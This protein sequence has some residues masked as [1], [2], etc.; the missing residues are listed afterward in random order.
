[1]NQWSTVFHS[2]LTMFAKVF[3]NINNIQQY[4]T[5]FDNIRQC[6]EI[7]FI[8]RNIW[9]FHVP[10]QNR[11]KPCTIRQGQFQMILDNICQYCLILGNA[12]QYL[13][14][15]DNICQYWSIFKSVDYLFSNFIKIF[16]FETSSSINQSHIIRKERKGW[17]FASICFWGLISLILN[18]SLKFFLHMRINWS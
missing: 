7:S 13:I 18:Q 14:R 4:Q 11:T 17:S 8:F 15:L 10:P 1:M 2:P 16:Y 3:I 6:S 12:E 9:Q 5:I